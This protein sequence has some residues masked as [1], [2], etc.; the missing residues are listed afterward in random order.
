MY[1]SNTEKNILEQLRLLPI[2][3][4]TRG[5]WSLRE[6]FSSSLNRYYFDSNL[7]STD[8][9]C[10]IDTTQDFEYYGNW[11]NFNTLEMVDFAEGDIYYIT[12]ENEDWLAENIKNIEEYGFRWIDW[13]WKNEEKVS[14]FLNKYNIINYKK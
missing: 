5:N 7:K 10:Q 4:T 2:S 14:S 12:F 3:R 8:G 11:V 1:M 6:T 9:W 13:M